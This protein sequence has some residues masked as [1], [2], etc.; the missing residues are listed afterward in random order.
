[1][2]MVLHSVGG[3]DTCLLIVDSEASCCISPCHGDFASD[4]ASSDIQ[5]TNLSST[6][7]VCVKG[8]ITWQVLDTNGREVEIKLPG[9]HVPLASVCLLSPQCLL[10]ADS[11]G[12]RRMHLSTV[13]ISTT[14]LLLTHL[15]DGHIFRSFP[16]ALAPTWSLAS[17]LGVFPSLPPKQLCGQTTFLPLAIQTFSQPR[18]NF[19]FGTIDSPIPST[20]HN[21]LCT[22][23]TTLVCSP[24]ELVPLC[25]RNLLPCKYKPS[26]SVTECLICAACEIAKAKRLWPQLCS[27][28]GS[29]SADPSSLKAGHTSL[30]DCFSCDH[31][32]SPTPGRVVSHS[33]HSFT[34]HGYVSGTIWVDYASHWIFHSPQHSLNSADTLHGELLLEREAADVGAT[35]GPFIRT[36]G[37]SIQ[38]SFVTIALLANRSCVLAGSVL[39]IRMALL[40][41]LFRPSLTWHVQTSFMH[42]FNDRNGLSLTCGL[43]LCR[44]QFKYTIASH[45]MDTVF[46][47]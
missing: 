36:M 2:E 33:G 32:I 31:Y 12:A 35:F 29:V 25:H 37:S 8:L 20:I 44:T 18:K 27:T 7:K 11:I 40:R 41:M 4:Y 42:C 13:S 45:L 16:S 14:I 19:F 23:H 9:Y 5:I 17:G 26:S 28:G 24:S 21:L 39:I 47:L 30:G 1:M 46:L 34:H 6:N 43:L 15:T 3:F 10:T 38:N 22:K